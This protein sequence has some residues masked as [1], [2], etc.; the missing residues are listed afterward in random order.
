MKENS[1]NPDGRSGKQSGDELND[2][3]PGNDQIREEYIENRKSKI[4]D[5]YRN[6]PPG[7]YISGVHNYCDRWCERCRLAYNCLVYVMEDTLNRGEDKA[8]TDA[9]VL[10]NLQASFMATA[11]MVKEHMEEMG[12]DLCEI[13]E[14][15]IE[16]E[17]RERKDTPDED[18][19]KE[20]AE[21][22]ARS[23]HEWLERIYKA[24]RSSREDIKEAVSVIEWYHIFIAAKIE[25]AL[26]S[27]DEEIEPDPIQNDINGSAKI[28]LLGIK[29]SLC[30]WAGLISN[31]SP[32]EDDAMKNSLLL[33][34]LK[35]AMEYRFPDTD[36]FIRPG[37]DQ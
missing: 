2:L 32:Y 34:K 22:Y 25:R 9:M 30:A 17:L 14:E 3:L 27:R 5:F 23:A 7:Q 20:M 33:C 21:H 6:R 37:F 36:K 28:A 11:E 26:C 35:A 4:R 16:D 18:A 12:F 10:E 31:E 8:I 19:L 1:K 15:E 13:D 24:K 29:N